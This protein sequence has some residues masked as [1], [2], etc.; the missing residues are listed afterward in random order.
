MVAIFLTEWQS[1]RWSWWPEEDTSKGDGVAVFRTD[2]SGAVASSVGVDVDKTSKSG[3]RLR[4][5]LC[6]EHDCVLN[7]ISRRIWWCGGVDAYLCHRGRCRREQCRRQPRTKWAA[8]VFVGDWC[9]VNVETKF[10]ENSECGVW[11]KIKI[12]G[13]RVFGRFTFTSCTPII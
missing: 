12:I 10:G 8:L 4:W 1:R 3:R 6:R 2:I 13:L 11:E 5:W 9:V 7:V